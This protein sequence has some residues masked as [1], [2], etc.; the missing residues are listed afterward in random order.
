MLFTYLR[1]IGLFCIMALVLFSCKSYE[2]KP[3]QEI[4]NVKS[5][6]IDDAIQEYFN[7]NDSIIELP[8]QSN[9]LVLYLSKNKKTDID[10]FYN[11]NFLVYEKMKNK[12]VYQNKYSNAEIKWFNNEQLL[13]IR[14][15]GTMQKTDINSI[16][17]YIIDIK[18][19]KVRELNENKS[20]I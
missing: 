14:Y 2:N 17:K 9:S 19:E 6:I 16:K 8:N 12:I 4:N 7:K 1:N 15:Y 18:S 11:I 20:N 3:N 5:N 10:P 13:L